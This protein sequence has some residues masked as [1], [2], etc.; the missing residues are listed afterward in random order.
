MTAVLPLECGLLAACLAAALEPRRSW[1]EVRRAV[2]S[3]LQN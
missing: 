2:C 3:G 1:E